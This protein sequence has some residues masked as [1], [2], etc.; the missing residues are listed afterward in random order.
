MNEMNKEYNEKYE[1]VWQCLYCGKQIRRATYNPNMPTPPTP[2]DCKGNPQYPN[3]RSHFMV[4][5]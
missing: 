3:K 5:V 4:K 2:N 1:F